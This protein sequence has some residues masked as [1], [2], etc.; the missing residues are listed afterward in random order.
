MAIRLLAIC[1]MNIIHR[2]HR[3]SSRKPRGSTHHACPALPEKDAKAG[4]TGCVDPPDPDMG[5][6]AYRGRCG[7]PEREKHS[8]SETASAFAS[9]GI[10]LP[11]RR[12]KRGAPWANRPGTAIVAC[13]RWAA[14]KRENRQISFNVSTGSLIE[15]AERPR[16]DP[17]R[18]VYGSEGTVKRHE[19][20]IRLRCRVEGHGSAAGDGGGA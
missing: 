2:P 4:H 19:R 8:R 14:K 20:T 1:S 6:R 15:R 18:A 11:R 17:T 3:P 9:L 13:N 10:T 16:I 5:D 12:G 7:D